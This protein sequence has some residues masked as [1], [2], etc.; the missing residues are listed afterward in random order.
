MAAYLEWA[1][2][3]LILLDVFMPDVDGLEVL[4][5]LRSRAKPVKILAL[6]GNPINGYNLC[7]IAKVFGAHE[8]LAKP[9]SGQDLLQRVEA[10]LSKT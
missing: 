9:F 1:E 2:P 10:L 8:T 4:W 3:A 6:S 5:Y 7:H